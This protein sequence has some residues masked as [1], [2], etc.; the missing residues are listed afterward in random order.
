M[1]Q[2]YYLIRNATCFVKHLTTVILLYVVGFPLCLSQCPNLDVDAGPDI[3]ICDT[4]QLIQLNG[5]ITGTYN[6]FFWTPANELSNANILDPFVINKSKGKHKF[7]LTAEGMS[8]NLIINGDFENGNT[9]F[10]TVYSLWFPPGQMPP[11]GYNVDTDPAPYYAPQWSPCTDHT[12]GSGKF[13][14]AN[15]SNICGWD[16][17]CETV[18]VKPN[19]DYTFQAF[20]TTMYPDNPP[21]ITI[22]FN[23][24]VKATIQLTSNVCDW[25]P[26]TFVWNSGGSTSVSICMRDLLCSGQW[27]ND[28]AV[29]DIS[30]I[31]PCA[32]SDS[33]IVNVVDLTAKL[34][35]LTKPKCASDTFSLS[36]IGSSTGPNIRYEWSTDVG[37]ILSTNGLSAKAQ[38]SGTY[39]LKIIFDDGNGYCEK[40]AMIIVYASD[41]E[42]SIEMDGVLSCKLDTV[43]LNAITINGSGNFKYEWSPANK[44]VKGQNQ[45]VAYVTQPGTYTL[46]ITD[47][48]SDCEK[49]IEIIIDLTD[50]LQ[51]TLESVGLISCK[52]DTVLLK[53]DVTNGTGQYTYNWTPGNYILR[54]QNESVA[55]V[56]EAGTYF[57][58]I[59]DK[60]SGCKKELEINI[61]PPDYPGGSLMIQGSANCNLDTV[62]LTADVTGGSDH[63]SYQWIPNNKILRGQ[64]ESIAYVIDAGTYK[65]KVKDKDT[66]CE[67]ELLNTVTGDTS[68]PRMLISTDTLISCIRNQ[69]FLTGTPFDTSKFSYDW[70]LPDSSHIINKDSILSK[71]AGLYSLHIIDKKNKCFTDNYWNIG[72]DTTKPNINLGPDQKLDCINPDIHILPTGNNANSKLNYQWFIPSGPLPIDTVLNNKFVNIPGMVVLKLVNTITGCEASDTMFI[73][74]VRRIPNVDA[75]VGTTLNCKFKDFSLDGSNTQIDSTSYFWSTVNGNIVSGGNSLHAIINAPG[76]YFINIED[77]TNHCKNIDSVFIDQNILAPDAQLGADQI[78]TCADTLLTIDGSNSSQG[79]QLK[80]NWFSINGNI[81]SGQ[82]TQ[83]ITIKSAGDYYLVV[84]D[85]INFC[86][87]TDLIVVKPD[88]NAPDASI[89]VNDTLTCINNSVSLTGSASSPI[90]NAIKYTWTSA[91]GQFIQNANSLSPIV[92]EPGEYIL[93]VIDLINGCS[94]TV[95]VEVQIDTVKP[96]AIAG[97]DNIWNCS[98]THVLLDGSASNGHNS[99]QFQWT[100]LDGSIIGNSKQS[101]IDV[102]TPGTYLLRVIDQFNG[103][104]SIDEV[105]IQKDLN[106]PTAFIQ[107]PDTLTCSHASITISG[108]GSSNGNRI[109]YDWKT[110][111]GQIIGATDQINIVIDKPGTYQLIVTDT[112]NKCTEQ[113]SILVIEDKQ[114][115]VVDAGSPA[116]LTCQTLDLILTGNSSNSTKSFLNWKTNQGNITSKTDSFQIKINK[117][118]TYY[119]EVTNESNGCVGLDSVLVTKRYNLV[120]NASGSAELT[121]LIK[122]ANLHGNVQNNAGNEQFIWTTNQGHFL[123]GTINTAQVKA[124]Q[125]GWYYFMVTNNITGCNGIDSV[126]ITE[127]TNVPVSLNLDVNQPKC[128][129][130]SWH[131]EITKITGGEKPIQVYLDNKLINGSIMQGI[132]AG[133]YSIKVVDKNGCELSTQ[134]D[135]ITTQGVSIQLIPLVK[136]FPGDDYNLVPMYSIPD[137][138]IAHVEWSPGDFLSCRDCPYP[139]IKGI[140]RDMDYFVTYTNHNGCSATARIRIELIERGIWVP[141]SFSPNG[142]NIN[143]SFYPVVTDGSYNIIR[144]M[145]IYDRWG[146]RVFTNENFQPNTSHEGWNGE[147]QQQKMNPGVFVYYIEV[148]WKNGET[149]ILKG[150][151]TLIK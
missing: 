106:I 147:F 86:L 126:L 69:I 2:E 36:G 99:L 101:K 135:I 76:W 10:N 132:A 89:I 114:T 19:T 79:N 75:G 41:L 17:W 65:V 110:N 32:Q 49:K 116:E 53:T 18:S 34:N 60:N 35:L 100:T 150:D 77:T 21:L 136:L 139:I 26:V 120:V 56:I 121:C 128:P 55:R 123:G 45:S 70:L 64:N 118:G 74:D 142:D 109:I 119:L 73:E 82:G 54:G 57:V 52:M 42:A 111:D 47:K 95:K 29:D 148:E 117:P 125:P 81:A 12:S 27:G 68:K 80:Y 44:I 108:Q 151:L 85:T 15:G 146:N 58:M 48:D 94:R 3:T 1:K 67:I 61:A 90:G 87:D 137:D 13:F 31:G 91:S 130:D 103:C 131:T 127:N 124:D 5:S 71:S 98:T 46:I 23:G 33:L 72:L 39:K 102:G 50:V 43:K 84:V 113:Q 88:L 38:G 8:A 122:E 83:S 92:N 16:F 141:N 138:S 22:A 105:V 20:F 9:G 62:A 30:L 66:G 129:G 107:T 143:D 7:V 144:S 24:S 28:L 78:F 25:I 14:F 4:N 134:F 97:P 40:E 63:F 6:N 59:E 51:A 133:N 149:Q 112:I 115:P 37:N 140:T 93:N 145:S 104:E 11:G 96:F